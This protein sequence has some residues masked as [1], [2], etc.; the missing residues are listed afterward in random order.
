VTEDV[1]V[2]ICT[3]SG[4]T[5]RQELAQKNSPEYGV[6]SAQRSAAGAGDELSGL[7]RPIDGSDV[8]YD[9]FMSGYDRAPAGQTRVEVTP[10]THPPLISAHRSGRYVIPKIYVPLVLEQSPGSHI[11]CCVETVKVGASGFCRTL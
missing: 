5:A 7:A 2:Q 6:L 1:S 4:C 10:A 8:Q 11:A 3:E 9:S